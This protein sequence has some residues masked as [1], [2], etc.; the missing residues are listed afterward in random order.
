MH[1][2]IYP[3]K[4]KSPHEILVVTYKSAHDQH[5]LAKIINNYFCFKARGASE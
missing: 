1:E 2:I 4:K 3:K 5:D